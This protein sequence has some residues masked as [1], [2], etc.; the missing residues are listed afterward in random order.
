MSAGLG[1][2]QC[3]DVRRN[4]A[5]ANSKKGI[6]RYLPQ[7][8]TSPSILMINEKENE[9]AVDETVASFEISDPVGSRDAA[10]SGVIIGSQDLDGC[11]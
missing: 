8:S 11:D 7:C 1:D 10:E 2:F 6:I 5:H 9:H 4:L 3:Q